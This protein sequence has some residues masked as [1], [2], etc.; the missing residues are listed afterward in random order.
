[1]K[2]FV[3]TSYGDHIEIISPNRKTAEKYMQGKGDFET[4]IES[5]TTNTPGLYLFRLF[6]KKELQLKKH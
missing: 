1:M 3:R 2:T 4:T 5:A 6:S